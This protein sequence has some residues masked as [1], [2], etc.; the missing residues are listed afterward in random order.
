MISLVGVGWN[1]FR[2]FYYMF[3]G[4]ALR[5]ISMIFIIFSRLMIKVNLSSGAILLKFQRKKFCGFCR[6]NIQ[7]FKAEEAENGRVLIGY[8][9]LNFSLL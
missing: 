1:C 7:S 6:V 3:L 8:N 5:V 2:S 9:S 4:V